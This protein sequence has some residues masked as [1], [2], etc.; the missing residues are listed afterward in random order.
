MKPWFNKLNNDRGF[1]NMINRFRSNHYNLNESLYRKGYVDSARCECD[2]EIQDVDHM[3]FSCIQYDEERAKLYRELDRIETSY[4]YNIGT[5]LKELDLPP[6][7]VVHNFL[8]K[9]SKII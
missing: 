4:I 6:L 1:V 7:R 2:I 9:I 8:R 5:W 3:T